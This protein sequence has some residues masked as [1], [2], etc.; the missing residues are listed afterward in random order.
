[1]VTS[2]VFILSAIGHFV[3]GFLMM[4]MVNWFGLISWRRAANAHWTERARLLHPVRFTSRFAVILSP[5][6]LDWIF[7]CFFP[8]A[9]MSL[10]PAWLVNIGAAMLGGLLGTFP[11]NQEIFPALRFKAWCKQ[12][13]ILLGLLFQFV[14]VIALASWLM[15]AHWGWQ[16][17]LVTAGCIGCLCLIQYGLLWRVLRMI[18]Q[19]QPAGAR[20]QRIVD[21][22]AAAMGNIKIRATWELDSVMANALALP[23]TK[24]MIFLRPTLAACT[25]EEIA[26][27]CAHEIAHLTEPKHVL[28]GR[29]LGSL[30]LV[31]FIFV[32]P[33]TFTFGVAGLLIP[34]AAVILVAR[35]MKWLGQRMEKR[36]DSLAAKQQLNE[37]VYARALE[38]LYRENLSPAVNASNRQTH[39]H[40]YDRMLAAGITPDFPRPARP[41]RWT[42]A[43]WILLI[44]CAMT[45]VISYTWPW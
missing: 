1:V 32:G 15:P 38:K 33:C 19:L 13:A 30:A 24:E 16:M 4:F 20:L 26:A 41:R 11:M 37:G 22:T 18:G 7:W 6:L 31:P 12:T 39:P 36:A 27:I 5:F 34:L 45:F 3:A 23:F 9:S 42:L 29:M 8:R 14:G 2:G 25:D 21:N 17:F 35:Y 44:G 43:G 28:A 10:E 40:L